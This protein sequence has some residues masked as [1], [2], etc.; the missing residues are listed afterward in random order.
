[1]AWRK[2]PPQE[3]KEPE[4]DSDDYLAMA[5]QIGLP[6]AGAVAGGLVGGPSGIAVGAGAGQALAQFG[7][8]ALQDD[9]RE[10]QRYIGQGVQAGFLTLPH[11]VKAYE[12]YQKNLIP[13]GATSVGGY[14]MQ[15]G[16]MGL[17][18]TPS[19]SGPSVSYDAAEFGSSWG[20]PNQPQMSL[21]QGWL[22][23]APTAP[24]TPFA[25]HPGLMQGAGAGSMDPRFQWMTPP[26][27]PSPY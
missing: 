23:G 16:Q 24:S 8:A 15:A 6:I 12:D 14:G 13:S 17:P 21:Q 3:I 25:P 2:I 4:M 18:P 1:M 26:P 20:D 27:I 9:P 7:T 11:G 19:F 5:M 22:E 10:A